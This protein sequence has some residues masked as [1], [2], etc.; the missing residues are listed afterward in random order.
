MIVSFTRVRREGYD[1]DSRSEFEVLA[2]D[3]SV[4]IECSKEYDEW[5]IQSTVLED[6]L[7]GIGGDVYGQCNAN[8]YKAA[9]RQAF[10]LTDFDSVNE[11][12]NS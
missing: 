11:A 8:S 1:F 12:L 2:D 3:G 10:I 4:L 6:F 9:L 5:T 7:S